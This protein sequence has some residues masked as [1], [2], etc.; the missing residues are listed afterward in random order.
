MLITEPSQADSG[1]LQQDVGHAIFLQQQAF[2]G[3][4]I[5]RSI[6]RARLYH[7]QWCNK[8]CGRL[9]NTT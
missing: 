5:P 1:G 3:I 6:F 7:H 8:F 4:H 2:L 9:Q